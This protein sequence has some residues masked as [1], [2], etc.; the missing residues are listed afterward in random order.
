MSEALVPLILTGEKSMRDR[1]RFHDWVIKSHVPQADPF[2]LVD[3][4]DPVDPDDP[5][6]IGPNNTRPDFDVAKVGQ[7]QNPSIRKCVGIPILNEYTH[8]GFGVCHDTS[9]PKLVKINV[10]RFPSRSWEVQVFTLSLRVWRTVY[11]G[12][13]FNS[14]DLFWDHVFIDGILYC[15]PCCFIFSFDLK[16]DKFGKVCLPER[17][18]IPTFIV[19]VKVNELLGLLE[20]YIEGG[21]SVYGVW[22]R[23][24]GVNQPFTKIYIVKVEGKSVFYNVLGFWNNGEVVLKM[25]DD[26]DDKE[27]TVEVYEPSSGHINGV[28][29]K[30]DYGHV[31]ATSYMETL[32][33]LD[34]SNSIIH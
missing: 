18:V 5:Y 11:M 25:A 13:P 16:S 27:S 28:R 24:D 15:T 34:Q 20:Y 7:N 10:V 4:A 33:L 9:D 32:L 31:S 2:D 19:V 3:P 17:F 1:G 12:A 23:K 22:M 6:S 26:D 14:C 30:G 29:I 8:L 21:M